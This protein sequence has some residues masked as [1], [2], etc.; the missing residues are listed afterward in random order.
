MVLNLKTSF[1]TYYSFLSCSHHIWER[2]EYLLCNFCPIS[3]NSIIW[4]IGS[5]G[6][7]ITPIVKAIPCLT[8][9]SLLAPLILQISLSVSSVYMRIGS[10]N[11]CRQALFNKSNRLPTHSLVW[12][13]EMNDIFAT[14]NLSTGTGASSENVVKPLC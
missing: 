6:Q 3:L 10:M 11:R 7:D 12:P 9:E 8:K 13:W 1:L 14:L 5:Q 4:L 2:N